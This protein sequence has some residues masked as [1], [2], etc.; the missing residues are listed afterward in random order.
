MMIKIY[1]YCFNN[2]IL[3]KYQYDTFKKFH[4]E[5]HELIIINNGPNEKYINQNKEMS[6]SLGL[7]CFEVP[8]KDHS[9]QGLS[10]QKAMNWSIRELVCKDDDIS[11]LLDFDI[12]QIDY[13]SFR[14]ILEN[15][16]VTGPRQAPRFP[17]G[18]DIVYEG[19]ILNDFFY[20]W[21]GFMILNT[22]NLPNI[23]EMDLSG[24]NGISD[25]GGKFFFYYRKNPH[26]KIGNGIG[27]VPSNE[28]KKFVNEFDQDD[29]INH[30]DF[31]YPKIFTDWNKDLSEKF[32]HMHKGSN[33]FIQ[34]DLEKDKAF[35]RRSQWFLKFLDKRIKET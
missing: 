32:I 2:P 34:Q 27:G 21:P 24:I 17:D 33:W 13:I 8:D 1:S 9:L 29:I 10:H 26:I 28:N 4:T 30:P 6:E 11:V 3:I 22:K 18:R 31:V 5:D 7:K 35:Q 23:K 16:D 25:S 15:F 19:E 20:I 12:F 14:D